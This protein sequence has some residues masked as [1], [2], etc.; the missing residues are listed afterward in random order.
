[1]RYIRTQAI[2][3]LIGL[4]IVASLLYIQSQGLVT[5]VMPA[6]GGT[7]TEATVGTPQRFNPL[8]E[9]TNPA[10][11]DVDRLLFSGL[12]KF[13][14]DGKPIIDLAQSYAVSNDGLSY[15]F[16]L[17]DGLRWHDGQPVT[18][19]DV[20]FTVGVLQA[21]DFPG[22]PD[23]SAFWQ[24]VVATSPS[25]NTVRFVLPEPFAPFLDYTT[26]GLLP[27]HL[28]KDQ[29]VSDLLDSPFN[30]NPVGTGPLKINKI[31]RTNGAITSVTLES[32]LPCANDQNYLHFVRFS[33]YPD[34]ASANTAFTKGE[35]QATSDFSPKTLAEALANPQID[36]FTGRLP[37]YNLIFLNQKT[38]TIAFF[39][40][41]K[42]RQ[43]LMLG[44]NR[45]WMIDNLLQGQALIATGPVL[46]GTWAYNDKLVPVA[47]DPK[48]AAQLLNDA[49]WALPPEAVKGTPEY[50]RT[51]KEIS[52][53]FTLLVPNDQLHLAIANVIKSNWADLGVQATL[54]TLPVADIK[55]AL[56]ARSFEAAMI[57]LNFTTTPD[58]DPYPFWHQTQIENG[59]NYS[60]FNNRDISELLEQARITPSYED[61]AK[62][63]RTFQSK[64]ADQTPALLLYYPVYNYAVDKKVSGVQMGPLVDPS[65][66]FN[67]LAD[68][69]MLTRRVIENSNQP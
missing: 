13:G 31:E 52:L 7:F 38:E 2:V 26:I 47:F 46:P 39:Q 50:V 60:S 59:Q 15:T 63:Y 12:M 35:A 57:D 1:M 64:F 40:E 19:A 61:R 41:K 6:C 28:L 65:D 56:E 54:T 49:G 51:K 62:F 58:P 11:R 18:E 29:K 9:S 43:A 3:A 25:R 44:M 33:Y 22:Q 10:E 66:R 5:R 37:Q 30:L 16:V 8:F 14:T 48:A 53:K 32:N 23:V 4:A 36:V 67:S 20:L 21:T 24:K 34:A 69:F 27:Q 45:Q 17:K 55:K 42:V 68:W